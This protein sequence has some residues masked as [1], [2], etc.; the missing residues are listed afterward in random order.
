[1]CRHRYIQ[2]VGVPVRQERRKTTGRCGQLLKILV[3]EFPKLSLP[4]LRTKL[5]ASL[6]TDSWYFIVNIRIPS[7]TTIWRFLREAQFFKKNP[8]LKAPLSEINQRK[9]LQFAE[10]WLNEPLGNVLWSDETRVASHPNNRRVAH[11]DNT[12]SRPI[13]VKMH[14]GGNSVMFWGCMSMHG[15]GELHSIQGSIMVV[16]IW[17]Y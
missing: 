14:S 12:N 5:A 2:E 15:T 16:S 11:W 10:K 17:R 13:Q 9:R 8:L 3:L 6:P 7:K 4:K 1:M